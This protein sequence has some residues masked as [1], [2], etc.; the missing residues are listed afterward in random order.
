MIIHC[1]KCA[2]FK[3]TNTIKDFY[4]ESIINKVLKIYPR[5]SKK[6]NVQKYYLF[7]YINTINVGMRFIIAMHERKYVNLSEAPRRVR[8]E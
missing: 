5:L 2:Q 8:C 7:Y 6:I 3:I 1:F 4:S